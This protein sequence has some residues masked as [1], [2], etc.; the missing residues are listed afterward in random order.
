MKYNIAEKIYYNE[1]LMYLIYQ[2]EPTYL[3]KHKNLLKKI[4]EVICDK[5]HDF[6]YNKYE[7][8][9]YQNEETI[10]IIELQNAF[11]DTLEL[12]GFII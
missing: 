6:W 10:I 11:F 8:A 3:D 5:A 1:D 7:K 9:F 2:Y 12:L 4:L